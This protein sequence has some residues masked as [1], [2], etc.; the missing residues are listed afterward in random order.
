MISDS[1]IYTIMLIALVGSV[2]AIR[3]GA[4]L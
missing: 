4:T 3:L 1:Q 2:L